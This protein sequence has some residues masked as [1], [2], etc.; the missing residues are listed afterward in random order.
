ME[1]NILAPT[2]VAAALVEGAG[3]PAVKMPWKPVGLYYL[4]YLQNKRT[5]VL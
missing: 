3:Q 5:T 1:M 4:V 2:E